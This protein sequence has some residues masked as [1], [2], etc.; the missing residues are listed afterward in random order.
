PP[1]EIDALTDATQQFFVRIRPLLISRGQLGLT[2][3]GHGDLHLGNIVL[4][5][6]NPVLFDAIEFDPLIAA[7]DI[8]YDLAFLLMDLV[9]RG[10]D[11]AANIVFNRYL[12]ETRRR[13]DLDALAALPLFLSV[14]AAIRAKVTAARGAQAEPKAQ[15]ALA[16]AAQKY[17]LFADQLIAPM[18]PVLIAVGG[19]SGTGKTL[20][21]RALAPGA[22]AVPGAVIVRSDVERKVLHGRTEAER[23]PPS[24]Y[25]PSVKARQFRN[26]CRE[27][28]SR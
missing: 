18:A 9:E 8:L 22:G 27:D 6:D 12:A 17:F 15:S 5:D 4:L 26:R 3:R 25:T 19:L 20:L 1:A 13:E 23:L 21:A 11:T 7:G 16:Q 28:P 14:R 10:L 24:A 2:H